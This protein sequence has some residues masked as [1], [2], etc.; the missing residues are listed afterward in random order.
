MRSI[1]P[2]LG[3]LVIALA[4]VAIVP[5]P[6][7]APSC[8][9]PAR[10]MPLGDSITYGV[11]SS[12]GSGYRAALWDRLVNQAGYPIDFVGSQ[13]S[14]VLPDTDNEGHSGWR[15]DQ[16]AANVDG[17]L[18]AYQPDIVLLHIGTNDM[19]QNYQTDIAPRRLSALLDQILVDRPA[20]TILVAKIVPSLD[21]IIQSRIT[22]FNAAVPAVA[23]A[24][25]NQVRLVD[26]SVL[27]SADLADTLHPNDNGY[28]RMAARWSSEL[29][30]VLSTVTTGPC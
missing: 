6:A 25:G 30:T 2:L 10:I 28:A 18:A 7:Q 3:V 29:E 9:R 14:G 4:A 23:A 15:I 12:T 17:W 24:H 27:S 26:L 16:I 11:G 5:T 8:T 19:N 1:R 21:P 22:A 13:H 20:T